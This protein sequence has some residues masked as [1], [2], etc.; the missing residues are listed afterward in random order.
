MWPLGVPGLPASQG[1]LW[2]SSTAS[3]TSGELA[4]VRDLLH[5]SQSKEGESS[6]RPGPFGLGATGT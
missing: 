4:A 5:S 1:I 3:G 2:P 6:K